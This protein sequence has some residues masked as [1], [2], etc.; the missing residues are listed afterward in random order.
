MALLVLLGK[1]DLRSPE[2]AFKA[3]H[4]LGSWL[5]GIFLGAAVVTLWAIF[6]WEPDGLRKL[7]FLGSVILLAGGGLIRYRTEKIAIEAEAQGSE[8][9][10]P[11]YRRAKAAL[12][13]V[14][15]HC[16]DPEGAH[17]R[18]EQIIRDLGEFALA[19]T[20]A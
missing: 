17:R 10:L 16:P 13:E 7:L 15:Q 8:M 1:E 5:A 20:E 9:A 3:P 6:G 19:E 18:R 11:I 2:L 14:E 12:D 4:I